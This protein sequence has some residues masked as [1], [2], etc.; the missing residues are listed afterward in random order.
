[1]PYGY[2]VLAS[3]RTI[4]I[5]Q[6]VSSTLELISYLE[7][8]TANL[9]S[10]NAPLVGH[11]RRIFSKTMNTPFSM[12]EFRNIFRG[13]KDTPEHQMGIEIL[14][15]HLLEDDSKLLTSESTWYKHYKRDPN[16]YFP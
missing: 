5:V 12:D 11:V 6:N 10:Y 4:L 9:I 2:T 14:R 15:Q 7:A 1:V 3:R 16:A 13:Y 8:K